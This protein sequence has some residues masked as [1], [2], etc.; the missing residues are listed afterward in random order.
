MYYKELAHV[1]MDAKKSPSLQVEK[2]A[3]VIWRPGIWTAN[4]LGLKLGKPGA[5]GQ[6]IYVLDQAVRVRGGPPSSIL[7]S[8]H[9]L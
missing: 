1:V 2:E 5:L 6:K 4:G 8:I 9:A 3:K 7:V